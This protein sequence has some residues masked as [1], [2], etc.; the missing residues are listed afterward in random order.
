VEELG[1]H[2]RDPGDGAVVYVVQHQRLQCGMQETLI[3]VNIGKPC[4]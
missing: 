4:A 1:V 3:V 2:Q